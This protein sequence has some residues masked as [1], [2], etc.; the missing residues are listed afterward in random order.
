MNFTLDDTSPDLGYTS[1]WAVQSPND[2]G[3]SHFFQGTYHVAQTTGANVTFTFT[4]SYIAIYGSKG[5]S[6]ASFSV[7]ADN[8]VFF[9]S[10]AAPSQQFQQILFEHTFAPP[11]QPGSHSI[12][13]SAILDGSDVEG[14]WLDLD[15]VSFTDGRC[16]DFN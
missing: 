8:D 2:P 10:A 13:L 6:H 15:Y 1:G 3:L 7:Q 4:G 11:S 9:L 14:R 12:T 5:P 16:V